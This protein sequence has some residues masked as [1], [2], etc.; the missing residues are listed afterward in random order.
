M[1]ELVYETDLK[2][3]ARKGLRDRDPSPAPHAGMMEM[4]D[5]QLSKSCAF[6]GV[7]DRSPLSAPVIII[8]QGASSR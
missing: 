2:S 8:S 1:S 3:V 6:N 4:V 7:R 5:M